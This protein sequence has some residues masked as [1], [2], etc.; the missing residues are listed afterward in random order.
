MIR[1]GTE[2]FFINKKIALC[3][4]QKS[5]FDIASAVGASGAA[6]EPRV[7][8]VDVKHVKTWS[9]ATDDRLVRHV[10]HANRTLSSRD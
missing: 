6:C 4:S 1:C 5:D 9:E 7:N 2:A 3:K 10:L 8:A